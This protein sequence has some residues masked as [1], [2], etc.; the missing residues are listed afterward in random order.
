M[1]SLQ[2]AGG[3]ASLIEAG[4]FLF[5]FALLVTVLAPL[6]QGELDGV[7]TVRF[8][9]EHSAIYYIWNLVIYVL[10]GIML[11]ILV[12][13]LHERLE[14]TSTGLMR[15][16]T[17]IGLIWAGLVIGS[18]IVANIGAATVTQL[19]PRE[20]EVA[21]TVWVAVDTVSRGLGGGNEVVGGVWVS[22]LSL[23]GLKSGRLP[24]ALSY[25]GVVSGTAGVVTLVPALTDVGAVFGLGLIVWFL[26]MGGVLLGRRYA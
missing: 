18:G 23:V 19:Y 24:K 9:A 22:L 16:A 15:V 4:T 25:L 12:L 1:R 17:A 8:L 6:V 26:W 7:A 5:G 21:A 3:I 10:F 11:V 20:P 13:A 14:E 2:K